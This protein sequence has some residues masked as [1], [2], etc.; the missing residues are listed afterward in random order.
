LDNPLPYTDAQFDL[1]LCA[2]AL[3]HVANLRGVV[4]EFARV[5]TPGGAVLITDFHPY[6]VSQGWRAAVFDAGTAYLLTYPGHTRDAYLDALTEA[7]LV[8]SRTVD[9]MMGEA[10]PGTMLDVEREG[11]KDIPF[12]FIALASKP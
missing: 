2:L 9:A 7:G 3:C 10:P 5:L 8:I 6:C 4:R 1:V 12:C 11:G